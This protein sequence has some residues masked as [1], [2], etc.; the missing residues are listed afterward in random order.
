MVTS[1]YGQSSRS[2]EG[3]TYKRIYEIKNKNLEGME[4]PG[5]GFTLVEKLPESP[6][7]SAFYLL[8]YTFAL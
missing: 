4:E 5:R 1:I 8:E 6:D 7:P 2:G 3:A